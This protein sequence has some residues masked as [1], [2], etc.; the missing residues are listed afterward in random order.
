MD[1]KSFGK[2][3]EGK[4]QERI[5]DSPNYRNGKFQ[6]VEPTEV[7]PGGT[8][9]FK[10]MRH[11]A[12]RPKSVRPSDEIPHVK[13]DLKDLDAAE[14]KPLIVWFG[15]SSYF[16]RHKGFNIL[17]DPVFSGTASPVFFFGKAFPGSNSYDIPD[18]PEIDLLLLTH[19]HY[20]HLDLPSIKKGHS[21]AKKVLT[22]LGVGAHL[23]HW[24]VDSEK[25][26]ELDWWESTEINSWI[27]ITATPA[28]HF[29]GRG[30]SR[31]NTLWS[32]FVLKLGGFQLYLGADSGYSPQFREIGEK[33]GNF[34][35]AFLE[36]GQYGKYWPQIHMFPEETLQAAKDINTKTLFPVHWG[37]FVLSTHPWN[38]PVQRLL[39]ASDGD[40]PEIIIPKIGET[41]RLGEN[42]AQE[43]WWEF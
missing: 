26:I 35:L 12:S 9:F 33:F 17:I 29:S 8:S 13:T 11:I 7:N 43:K 21:K 40:S 14:E 24:G 42:Y 3:P 15:H 30:F 38:E 16:I 41:Y 5:E 6:N 2:N 28:R 34:D 31:A 19:D 23:E 10:I 20:D 39:R 4:R 22:S 1:L 25:I 37:K 32:S 18:F 36:C 27:S